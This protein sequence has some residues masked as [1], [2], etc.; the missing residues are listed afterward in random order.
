MVVAPQEVDDRV[1]Q[2]DFT[3]D[4]PAVEKER[5]VITVVV[6]CRLGVRSSL[7]PGGPNASRKYIQCTGRERW[8]LLTLYIKEEETAS[9]I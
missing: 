1:G 3:V 8:G 4:N 5:Q 6:N 9:E 2:L 7:C